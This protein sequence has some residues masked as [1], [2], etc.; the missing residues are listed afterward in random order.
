MTAEPE[1]EGEELLQNEAQDQK[2]S[3]LYPASA[4]EIGL[5]DISDEFIDEPHEWDSDRVPLTGWW[6][7]WSPAFCCVSWWGSPLL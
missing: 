1:A 6:G 7:G 5:A 2:S 4:E 3:V